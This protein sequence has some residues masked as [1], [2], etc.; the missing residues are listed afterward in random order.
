MKKIG[1]IILTALTVILTNSNVFAGG[2]GRTFEQIYM[3]CGI[4]AMI[5]QRRP[6]IASFSNATW[7]SGTTA[8][9]SNVSSSD[10][11]EGTR[12]KVAGFIFQNYSELERDLARGRGKFISGLLESAGCKAVAHEEITSAIRADFSMLISRPKHSTESRYTQAEAFFNSFD[13][14]VSEDFSRSCSGG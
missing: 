14:R 6:G 10:T 2:G 13:K 8:I 9:S 1:S 5:F 12:T 3:E 11:C 4:G 7:D